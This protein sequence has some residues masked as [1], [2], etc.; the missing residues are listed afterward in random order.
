MASGQLLNLFREE[1]VYS[2]SD[3]LVPPTE[4]KHPKEVHKLFHGNSFVLLN[5]CSHP[6]SWGPITRR[7][8]TPSGPQSTGF[9]CP[10]TRCSAGSSATSST[11]CCG[12]DTPT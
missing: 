11:S 4:K 3:E 1:V 7:A 9:L 2:E 8:P 12:T 6:A 10:A 5:L